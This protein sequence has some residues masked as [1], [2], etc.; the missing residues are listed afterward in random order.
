[1]IVRIKIS[2]SFKGLIF[3]GDRS[4]TAPEKNSST[5]LFNKKLCAFIAII[6][7]NIP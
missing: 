2:H 3:H 1:M 4:I 6:G 7:R 5:V